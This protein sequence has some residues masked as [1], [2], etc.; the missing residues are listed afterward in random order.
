MFHLFR[1]IKN[2]FKYQIKIHA[3]EIVIRF[4]NSILNLEM[5]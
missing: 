1:E 5:N 3:I 4:K 2:D